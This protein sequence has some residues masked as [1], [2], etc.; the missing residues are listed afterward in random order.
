MKLAGAFLFSLSVLAGQ[1]CVPGSMLPAG[2]IT[3]ALSASSCQLSDGSAYDSYR[4]ALPVRGLI[5]IG[6][7]ATPGDLALILRDATGA[8]L[9]QGTSIQRPIEAGFYTLLVNAQPGGALSSYAVQSA[10]TPET[11]M[12]CNKF[13]AVG[14]NQ[15]VNGVLGSSGCAMPSGTSYEGYT[16]STYG[17]GVLSVAVTAT[18]FTPVLIVRNADGTVAASGTTSL[19]AVVSEEAQYEIVVSTSDTTGAY[20]LT[21]SFDP[22]ASETCF[23]QTTFS[24]PGQDANAITA[25]GCSTLVAN[26][27]SPTYF[28]YYYVQVTAAGLAEFNVAGSGLAPAL[29]LLDA[30]GNSLAADSGG[31]GDGTSDIRMQVAPGNYLVV[32]SS[33]GIVGN[34]QLTYAFTPGAPQ[35]CAVETAQAAGAISGTLASAA[36]CRTS[37]GLA[38]EYGVTLA[39]AGTLDVDLATSNFTG[40]VALADAKGN[41]IYL[42]SDLDDL[43]DSNLSAVLPAGS[44]TILAAAM[45]GAGGYQL[46]TTFTAQSGTAVA[47]CAQFVGLFPNSF[48]ITDLGSGGCTASDGQPADFYQFTLSSSGVVAAVMTSDQIQGHLVLAD[49]SANYLRSD[50]DSYGADDPLIVQFLQAG[51]YQLAATADSGGAGGLY[52]VSLLAAYGSRPAFCTPLASLTPGASVSGTLAISSCQY[53]D[54]TFADIYSLTLA[55]ATPVDLLLASTD[56]DAYLVVLDAQGD[57]VAQDDDSG[58]GTNAEIVQALPAGTYYVVAK[59]LAYYYSTGN[60]TLTLNQAAATSSVRK[61]VSKPVEKAVK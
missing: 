20:Q 15:T 31:G 7:T 58:G 21:T 38:D 49:S 4:L 25:A 41:I 61:R 44:Y 35:P 52:Q 39:S 17:W 23:P 40:Q 28:N 48:Y 54:G 26:G 19:T 14:L 57:V 47:A 22:D 55:S 33:A 32:V 60:Y 37:L 59:P 42:N 2:Q 1:N 27:D 9:G 10:F 46:T 13:P 30:A 8:S 29:A 3:G 36:S 6:L 43:G 56:F 34:Y 51:T 24:E 16:L 18:G 5:Q 50:D 53:V 12:L 45:A 11:G